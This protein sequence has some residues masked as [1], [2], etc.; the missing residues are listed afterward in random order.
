MLSKPQNK[1]VLGPRGSEGG[2][3]GTLVRLGCKGPCFRWAPISIR[4]T[5][6]IGVNGTARHLQAMPITTPEANEDRELLGL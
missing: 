2:L 6:L 1:K 4:G 5:I 3:G